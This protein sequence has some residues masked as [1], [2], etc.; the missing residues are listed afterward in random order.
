MGAPDRTWVM[1][2][3]GPAFISPPDACAATFTGEPPAA[4]MADGTHGLA[5]TAAVAEVP[6]KAGRCRLYAFSPYFR[7]QSWAAMR[8]L[9]NGLLD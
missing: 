5:G 2:R 9:F 3:G 1:Y 4:G 7:A 6:V 8:W